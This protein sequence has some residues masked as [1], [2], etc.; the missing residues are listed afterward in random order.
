MR[1]PDSLC[2]ASGEAKAK[3]S[4]PSMPK[5]NTSIFFHKLIPGIC[6]K[7]EEILQGLRTENLKIRSASDAVRSAIFCI[8]SKICFHQLIRVYLN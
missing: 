8:F 3:A 6:R 2:S 1:R 4:K 5:N 7:G